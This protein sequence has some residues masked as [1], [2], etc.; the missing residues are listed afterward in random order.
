MNNNILLS[1]DYFVSD[2]IRTISI[3]A[4][5]FLSFFCFALPLIGVILILFSYGF[6][7]I[8]I[9]LGSG[10]AALAHIKG[11]GDEFKLQQKSN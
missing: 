11:L 5:C 2:F 3:S 9:A 7:W 1:G 4:L 10:G 6:S 8:N